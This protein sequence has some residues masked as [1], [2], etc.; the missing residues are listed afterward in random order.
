M[1]VSAIQQP[2]S[3]III[4][5]SPWLLAQSVKNLPAVWETW[6]G[7]LGREDPLEKEMATHS[8]IIAWRVPWTEEPDRYRPWGCKSRT[9]LSYWIS[10]TSIFSILLLPWL[11]SC[12]SPQTAKLG[13]ALYSN[14]SQLSVLHKLVDICRCHFLCFPH[15]FLPLLCQRVPSLFLRL[16]IFPANRSINAILLD[17]IQIG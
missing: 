3:V 5:M 4:H 12:R 11:H 2:K 8:R 17:P 13:P 6:V 1:L 10:T 9:W 15:S 7:S 14:L 16:Y